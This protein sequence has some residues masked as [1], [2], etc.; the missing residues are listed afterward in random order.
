M[1]TEWLSILVSAI[2]GFIAGLLASIFATGVRRMI[3]PFIIRRK[4]YIGNIT[5]GEELS[6]TYWYIPIHVRGNSLWNLL[7][8][9]VNDVKAIIQFIE[10]KDNGKTYLQKQGSWINEI[11]GSLE[12]LGIDTQRDIRI[13]DDSSVGTL[14]PV[15]A[16]RDEILEGN[17]DISLELRSGT[18]SL[19]RW[20]F[21]KAIIAG[22]M[23]EVSP[24]KFEEK[25]SQ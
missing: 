24:T 17:Q 5:R 11:D 25:V 22:S 16:M 15:N 10:H 8:S 20:L 7:V 13:T 23:Q 12:S 9:S 19:G 4:L 2:S 18:I 1:F 6:G 21:V 14:R 3:A